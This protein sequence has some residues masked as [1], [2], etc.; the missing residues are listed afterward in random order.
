M[1]NMNFKNNIA[2]HPSGKIVFKRKSR[3]FCSEIIIGEMI[4]KYNEVRFHQL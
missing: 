2:V 3:V 4:V 1:K